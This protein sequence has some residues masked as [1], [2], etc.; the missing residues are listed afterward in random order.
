VNR[1]QEL[2]FKKLLNLFVVIGIK[3]ITDLTLLHIRDLNFDIFL[4][5]K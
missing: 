5:P 4:A 2:A 1:G 3:K